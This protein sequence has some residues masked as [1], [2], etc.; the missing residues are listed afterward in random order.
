MPSPTLSDA[1]NLR[2]H[3]SNFAI[4][5]AAGPQALYDAEWLLAAGDGSFAYGIAL[6][7]PRK[8][9]HTL[10]NASANPPVDRIAT[11]HRIGET[12]HIPGSSPNTLGG[13]A[14]GPASREADLA[15]AARHLIRFERTPTHVRWVYALPGIEITKTL[16]LA[17][18]RPCATITYDIRADRAARIDLQPW[19]SV[20]DFHGILADPAPDRLTVE[21]RSD[22]EVALTA[23]ARTVRIR[24]SHGAFEAAPARTPPI[25]YDREA[26]RGLADAETLVSPGHFAVPLHPGTSRI[27]LAIALHPH[28]PDLA[29]ADDRAR[30]HHLDAIAASLFT[31]RPALAPL[32]PILDSADEFL[33]TRTVDAKPLLTVI[34]GYPWFADWGRDTMISLQGLMLAAGRHAD[35]F[36]CLSTFARYTSQGMIPNHFDDYGGPPH[37]NTVDASLWFLH[38]ATEYLRASGDRAGFDAAL[39]SACHEII[40][41][42]IRGTRFGIR[43][44]PAD[45]LIAAGDATTQLT[46]MD[47]KRNNIVFTPRHGKAVEINALWHHGLIRIAEAIE[48]SDPTR[49]AEYRAIAARTR[50]SFN[51]VFPD[52]TTGGLHDCLRPD[53]AGRFIPSGE[54][55]PNQIFAVSLE[56]SP[57]HDAAKPSVLALVRDRLL[58]PVG[59]RTLAPGSPGYQPR[60]A[61][62]MMSRDRAYHNGTV[63]PWLIGPFVEAHLR[64]HRFSAE[65]RREALAFIQPLIDSMTTDC[66]GQI[67]E[68]LDADPPRHQQGCT[69]QAWSVAEVFRAAAMALDP[70]SA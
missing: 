15:A 60:F 9:Y 25:H 6:G 39:L 24:C 7:T 54:L 37:Y 10:L 34:A 20:R 65:A 47:A 59:L 53:A 32:R 42:T 12:I 33:V 69:A 66:L 17:W 28:E 31:R 49:A 56:H 5:A 11:V 44:D 50:A 41:W 70:P 35:A 43:M 26:E 21:R 40:A 57:L 13:W 27:V 46:W 4:D 16:R 68:V 19:A 67:T 8:K 63:W 22:R 3:P 58:T 45:A 48:T 36:A 30:E 62:D 38:G 52:P 64:V 61:G 55:R 29:I 14:L 18:R 1:H 2:I 23:E 51:T